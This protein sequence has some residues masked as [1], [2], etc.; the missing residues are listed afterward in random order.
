MGKTLKKKDF[1]KRKVLNIDFYE[2]SGILLSH[3]FTNGSQNYKIHI[4]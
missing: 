1:S 3:T 4:T 2:K